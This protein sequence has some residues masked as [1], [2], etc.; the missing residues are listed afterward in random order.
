VSAAQSGRVPVIT[1]DGPSGSGK[2]VLC[3]RLS[4]SL[5]FHLLDSG[6]LYRLTA[7]VASRKSIALDDAA[8]LARAAGSLAVEFRIQEGDSPV[9]ALL[10][11][12]DVE[13]DLRSED[14]AEAASRVAILPPVRAA[15]LARQRG[16][17]RPPG[18]VADGRDM[19]TVVFPDARLK[20]FLTARAEVRADRRHK[21]LIAKGISA[22]V[23]RLLGEI[24]ERDR[25]D[26]GRAVAPL[27]PAADAVVI[28]TS[29]DSLDMVFG[30]VMELVASRGISGHGSG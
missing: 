28:D 5:G 8:A 18:L 12:E 24:R 6:A 30:R 16:F 17:R 13:R 21:Q 7:L 26:S 25:R 19:G 27:K 22:N 3:V 2:G 4:R 14:C 15:L 1:V 9:T 20:L 23:P 29:D 11:G 10:D